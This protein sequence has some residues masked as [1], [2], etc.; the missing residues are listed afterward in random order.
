[1]GNETLTKAV[2]DYRQ[3][4]FEYETI[5][6]TTLDGF[7]IIDKDGH[8]L[9]VNNAYCSMIGYTRNELLNMTIMDIKE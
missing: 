8:F 7:W 6:K 5:L 1:M 2:N 4:V 9:E 3:K